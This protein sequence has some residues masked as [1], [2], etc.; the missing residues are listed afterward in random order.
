MVIK[1]ISFKEH[2]IKKINGKKF[3]LLG[4]KFTDDQNNEFIWWPKWDNVRFILFLSVFT[5]WANEGINKWS[6]ME[7]FIK[8]LEEIPRCVASWVGSEL[9]KVT[10]KLKNL[11]DQ[12]KFNEVAN[13]LNRSDLQK[14]MDW[15]I[16]KTKV[17]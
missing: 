12:G 13:I 4:F 8:D 6:E 1:N 17:G 16:A 14:V 11:I 15:Y 3:G 9:P 2:E 10:E 7:A 5:E